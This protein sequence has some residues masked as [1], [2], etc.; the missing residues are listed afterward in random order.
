MGT[1]IHFSI[2]IALLFL[3][4]FAD[5]ETGQTLGRHPNLLRDLDGA[6][7]KTATQEIIP[8]GLKPLFL[9]ITVLQK[10]A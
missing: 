4:A 9:E 3:L 1:T 7:I 5:T 6:L 8:I 2:A 10:F